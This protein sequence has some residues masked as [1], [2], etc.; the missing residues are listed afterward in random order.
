MAN[1]ALELAIE[2]CRFARRS[3]RPNVI[4]LGHLAELR[5]EY[6]EIA[7][8]YPLP[9]GISY[10]PVEAGGVSAEWVLPPRLTIPLRPI[11]GFSNSRQ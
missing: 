9:D 1:R 2:L 4:E 5:Y 10:Q 11:D 6:Q 3:R 7:D 8:H